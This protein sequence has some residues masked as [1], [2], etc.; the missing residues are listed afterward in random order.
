MQNEENNII[1]VHIRLI[2]QA[3]T[4]IL[5]IFFIK[6]LYIWDFFCNFASKIVERK[7]RGTNID[8]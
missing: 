2:L 5:I 8:Y 6:I 3:K 7:K 4:I 1:I